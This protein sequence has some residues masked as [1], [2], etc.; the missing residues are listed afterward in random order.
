VVPISLKLI[1]RRGET[2]FPPTK[3]GGL[4]FKPSLREGGVVSTRGQTREKK[5]SL[6]KENCLRSN[7]RRERSTGEKKD[8]APVRKHG[9]RPKQ[10]RGLQ[11]SKHLKRRRKPDPPRGKRRSDQNLWRPIYPPKT[12][13]EEFPEKKNGG[14]ARLSWDGRHR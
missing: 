9:S 5:K 3:R 13:S 8:T 6:Y 11:Q 1:R 7:F 10:Q 4:Y 12:P 2:F 14:S